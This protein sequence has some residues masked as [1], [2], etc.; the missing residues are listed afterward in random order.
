M[1]HLDA[2]PVHVSRRS[3]GRVALCDARVPDALFEM[4]WSAPEALVALGS[5]LRVKGARQTICLDWGQRRYVLKHYVEPSRRHAVK[6]AALPSRARSTWNVMHKLAA[7]GVATPQPVACVENRWGPLRRD[8]FLLYPYQQG[9]TLRA[10]LAG[11]ADRT[12]PAAERLWVQL[13]RLW[14]RLAQL[15]ASL[16]DTNLGNFI[17]CPE[18]RLWVIDLDKARFHRLALVAARHQRRGWQQLLRSAGKLTR[19]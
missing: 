3:L 7:A 9:C 15:R 10:C 19:A 8:S 17:V 6:R 14:Q 1:N 5:P 18:G 13:E 11:E 16:A 4:L 2:A 12:H